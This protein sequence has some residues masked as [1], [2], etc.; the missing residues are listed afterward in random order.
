MSKKS[1][2]SHEVVHVTGSTA[3]CAEIS[4]TSGGDNSTTSTPEL[5]L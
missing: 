2:Y 3:V 4:E 5:I 1:R